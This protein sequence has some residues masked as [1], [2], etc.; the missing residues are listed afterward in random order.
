MY[1]NMRTYIIQFTNTKRNTNI[2]K[3][4]YKLA[5]SIDSRLPMTGQPIGYNIVRA[6]LVVELN[7]KL[8]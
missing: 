4:L 7:V 2:M 5:D 3:I 6:L 1:T 8:L